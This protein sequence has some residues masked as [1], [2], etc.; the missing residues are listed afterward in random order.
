M[1]TKLFLFP[2]FAEDTFCY[3]ELIPLIKNYEFIHVDYRPILD[4]FTLPFITVQQFS[5]HLIKHY[6]IQPEDKIIGHSMGGYF[7]FQVREIIGTEICMIA[8]FN[9]PEKVIHI[10][11]QFPRITFLAAFSGLLKT[12]YL[13]NY[14]L[15]K[16]KD[17]NYKNIQSKI[18][19]NFN[20]FTNHEL[21]LMIEMNYQPKVKSNLPNPLR[22]H[23]KNDKVIAFPDEPYTQ[24]KGGHFCLNLFPNETFAAM[25]DFLK[26]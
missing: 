25:Q 8:G 3:N 11:P 16:I 24:V 19:D 15:S 4:K 7:A 13:K 26:N 2:G 10:L 5:N 20:A 18:M 21:A 9:D 1:S 23:D 6:N 22:I 17:E 14:L 12:S